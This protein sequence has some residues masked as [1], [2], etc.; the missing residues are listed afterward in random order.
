M[1]FLKMEAATR[2]NCANAKCRKQAAE[3]KAYCE[4]CQRRIDEDNALYCRPRSSKPVE[5]ING[6][7]I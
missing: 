2:K 5:K 6:I 7:A 1:E 4:A 3:T